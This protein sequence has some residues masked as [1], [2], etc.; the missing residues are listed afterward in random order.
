MNDLNMNYKWSRYQW[1]TFL[2]HDAFMNHNVLNTFRDTLSWEMWQIGEKSIKNQDFFFKTD[3]SK[4]SWLIRKCQ[5][6]ISKE[7]WLIGWIAR[8][9]LIHEGATEY[10]YDEIKERRYIESDKI[11][12]YTQTQRTSCSA[13]TSGAHPLIQ[14]TTRGQP[15]AV[16]A[17]GKWR[18]QGEY[19]YTTI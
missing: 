2:I 16:R 18:I 8:A 3:T 12:F 11:S 19:T 1:P 7:Q 17:Q 10:R 9:Y 13:H 15:K 5:W 14:R 4:E 6:L